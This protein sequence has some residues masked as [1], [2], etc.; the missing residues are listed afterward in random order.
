LLVVRFDAVQPCLHAC[1]GGGQRIHAR[2]EGL[3]KCNGR[4]FD[5]EAH[6]NNSQWWPPL[7]CQSTELKS[8]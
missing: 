3:E 4:G 7:R 2:E 8:D 6:T 5:R 1:V